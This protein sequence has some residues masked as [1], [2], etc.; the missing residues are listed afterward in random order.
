MYTHHGNHR[1]QTLKISAHIHSDPNVGQM[2]LRRD[3]RAVE[4]SIAH[5]GRVVLEKPDAISE[6]CARD[7]HAR[8]RCNDEGD[9][10]VPLK[11]AKITLYCC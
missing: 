10:C 2:Q 8:H 6:V 11:M 4:D 9:V 7:L 1:K 3:A 5:F